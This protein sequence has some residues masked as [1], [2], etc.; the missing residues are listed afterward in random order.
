MKRQTKFTPEEQQQHAAEQQSQTQPGRE[1]ANAD[2]MLRYDAAQTT[3]PPVVADRLQ[4]S[5]GDSPPP[6]RSW[7]RRLLGGANQ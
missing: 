7:W 4:Q 3:V 1:F 6:A 2:E 5:I